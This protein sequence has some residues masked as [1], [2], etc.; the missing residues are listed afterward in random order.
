VAENDQ[1]RLEIAFEG[2]QTVGGTVTSAV[3]DA[4]QAAMAGNGPV[5]EL[6]TLEGNYLVALGKVVYVKRSARGTEIGFGS[7]P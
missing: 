2:G 5:F 6:E 3:S 1:I 7:T 4:F